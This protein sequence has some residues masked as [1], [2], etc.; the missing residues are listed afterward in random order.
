[1]STAIQ[2]TLSS[3][4]VNSLTVSSL[5]HLFDAHSTDTMLSKRTRHLYDLNLRFLNQMNSTN[6]CSGRAI[7]ALK[8]V[9]YDW[10]ECVFTKS[11]APLHG[12]RGESDH[13]IA[14]HGAGTQTTTLESVGVPEDMGNAGDVFDWFQL[15]LN[16]QLIFDD[17][18]EGSLWEEACERPPL[19]GDVQPLRENDPVLAACSEDMIGATDLL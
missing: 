6:R 7:K 14:Q 9:E 16:D 10:G 13:A 8:S 15:P 4:T 5:M 19:M 3:F 12:S 1:M 17:V 11:E 18:L 2:E